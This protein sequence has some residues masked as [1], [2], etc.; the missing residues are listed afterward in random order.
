MENRDLPKLA[1]CAFFGIAVNQMFF[2]K[3]LSITNPIN[4]SILMTSTPILVLIMAAII[5]KEKVTKSKV[6][7][8]FL[9]LVGAVIIIGMGE[10]FSFGSETL[11]GDLLVFINAS[12]YGIYLVMVKPFMKKYQPLT[13]IKW[14]FFFG[15]WMVLPFGY[16]EFMAIEWAEMPNE[17]ILAVIYVVIGLSFFAYLFNTFALKYVSPSLVS[18][19]IYSQPVFATII[20]VSLGKDHLSYVKIISAI[21]IFVGVYLVSKPAK[22]AT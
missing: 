6:L 13:V 16:N 22:T 20:A 14:I 17:I 8:I 11:L 12:S 1:L 19:Y 4:A 5:I 2:F 18:I 21:L 3:G 9:G 7:G 15:F 10:S